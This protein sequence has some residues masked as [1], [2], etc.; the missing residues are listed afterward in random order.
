MRISIIYREDETTLIVSVAKL[1]KGIKK[2]I[3]IT[4]TMPHAIRV[5]NVFIMFSFVL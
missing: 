3:T 4:A 1:A 5:K 2:V